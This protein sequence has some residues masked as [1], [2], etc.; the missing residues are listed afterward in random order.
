MLLETKK[1][2]NNKT[3]RVTIFFVINLTLHNKKC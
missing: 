1:A 2:G 3:K